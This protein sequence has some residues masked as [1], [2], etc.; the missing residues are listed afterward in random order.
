MF[1]KEVNDM[2]FVDSKTLLNDPSKVY[3]IFNTFDDTSKEVIVGI[4]ISEKSVDELVQ[5]L[6]LKH[7]KIYE[8]CRNINALCEFDSKT[9]Q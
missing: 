1:S 5:D 8:I 7:E 9:I 3:S 4:C 6:S 2:S